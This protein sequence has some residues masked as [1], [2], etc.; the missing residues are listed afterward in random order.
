MD[1]PAKTA[2]VNLTGA[3]PA[4]GLKQPNAV[5]AAQVSALG[6]G[7]QIKWKDSAGVNAG[8]ANTQA[9]SSVAVK[10]NDSGQY[11]VSAERSAATAAGLRVPP[12]PPR[13]GTQGN[14]VVSELPARPVGPTTGTAPWPQGASGFP[15]PQPG[16]GIAPG[17]PR[18]LAPP[19]PGVLPQPGGRPAPGIAPGT[20]EPSTAGAEKPQDKGPEVDVGTKTGSTVTYTFKTPQEAARASEVLR[21]GQVTSPNEAAAMNEALSSQEVKYASTA[22]TSVNGVNAEEAGTTAIKENYERGRTTGTEL[23]SEFEVTGE[24]DIRGVPVKAGDKVSFTA[25]N[26]GGSTSYESATELSGVAKTGD[27]TMA[28]V[29]GAKTEYKFSQQGTE[30]STSITSQQSAGAQ[31]GPVS[32]GSS[33]ELEDRMYRSVNGVTAP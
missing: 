11:E 17:G 19:A 25:I 18:I 27:A 8:Q 13:P 29:T 16:I 15:L 2:P 4:P 32:M 10:K 21:A 31:A 26:K 20:T 7:D 28:N 33:V 22:K 30:I 9:E 23:K 5:D 12:E 24:G 14:Q 3:P 1:D 6:A